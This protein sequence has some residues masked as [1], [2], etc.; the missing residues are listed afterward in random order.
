ML[1][2]HT[3]SFSP[4]FA[5]LEQQNPWYPAAAQRTDKQHITLLI[6]AP[7]YAAD[8]KNPEEMGFGERDIVTEDR[9]MAW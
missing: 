8:Q 4:N 2:E 7:K 1:A 5:V 9:S 6:T 3:N